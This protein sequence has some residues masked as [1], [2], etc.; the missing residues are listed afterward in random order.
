MKHEQIPYSET[1]GK[2]QGPGDTYGK[3]QGPN[4][5]YGKL[6]GPGETYGKYQGHVDSR[7]TKAD[8]KAEI[9]FIGQIVGGNDFETDDGLFCELAI[10]CGDGWDVL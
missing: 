6:Q 1:Y 9:H 7:V 10:D 4:D 2:H 8:L 3:F 5:T